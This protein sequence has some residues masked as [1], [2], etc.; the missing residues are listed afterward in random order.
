M[1]R[2][3]LLLAV[4]VVVG[5]L[6]GRAMSQIPIPRD[7]RVFWLGNLCAP[8]LLLA[9]LAGVAQRGRVWGALAGAATNVGCVLGFYAEFLD[10]SRSSLGLPDGTPMSSVVA[11]TVERQIVFMA[12][13]LAAAVGGGLVYGLLGWWWRT[14]RPLAAAVALGLPFITEPAL[15]P[16]QYGV[17]RGPWPVW[18]LEVAAGLALIAL[19]AIRRGRLRAGGTDSR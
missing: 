10:F 3:L 11:I 12:P 18:A 14:A 1:R 7:A 13:W 2:P 16:L 4:S 5:I 8:W 15:W 17:Y 9:F 19:M 6:F